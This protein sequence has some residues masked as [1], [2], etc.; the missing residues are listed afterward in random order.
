MKLS[1]NFSIKDKQK[2]FAVRSARAGEF[3]VCYSRAGRS[4]DADG[5]KKKS[6][7]DREMKNR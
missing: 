5:K 2:M 7:A 1:V 3:N 6:V 4:A